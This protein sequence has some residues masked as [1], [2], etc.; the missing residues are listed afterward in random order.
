MER[1][2][3]GR[4]HY[5]HLGLKTPARGAAA[6]NL[7]VLD[8]AAGIEWRDWDGE[9]VVYVGARAS[10]HLLSAQASRIFLI[11]ANLP[12]LIPDGR[13]DVVDSAFEFQRLVDSAD[14]QAFIEETLLEFERLGLARTH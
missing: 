10:T 3:S 4:V 9:I 6:V 8:C 5:L 14:D 12:T 2:G 1:C 7:R 11:L 13:L